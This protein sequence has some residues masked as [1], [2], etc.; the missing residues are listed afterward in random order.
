MSGEWDNEPMP[1]DESDVLPPDAR[2][3]TISD[4]AQYIGHLATLVLEAENQR[5]KSIVVYLRTLIE[6]SLPMRGTSHPYMDESWDIVMEDWQ[7]HQPEEG[8]A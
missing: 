1:V 6:G 2:L 7:Q 4:E 8:G 5:L 3:L